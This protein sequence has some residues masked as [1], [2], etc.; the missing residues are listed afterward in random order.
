MVD[1]GRQQRNRLVKSKDS[2]AHSTLVEI[3]L[4]YKQPQANCLTS[5][6]L[7]LENGNSKSLPH[8]AILRMN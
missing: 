7:H 1:A 5:L 2:V 8:W 6:C 4:Y 3:Y